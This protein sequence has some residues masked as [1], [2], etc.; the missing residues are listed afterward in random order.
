MRAGTVLLPVNQ[1]LDPGE[2]TLLKANSLPV[3]NY[4]GFN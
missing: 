1:A 4:G 3:P 2:E